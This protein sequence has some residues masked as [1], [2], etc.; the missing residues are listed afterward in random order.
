M[1]FQEAI[2]IQ[3]RFV[4][5]VLQVL[6]DLNEARAELIRRGS[7]AGQLKAGQ[8]RLLGEIDAL[9]KR[10]DE[11]RLRLVEQHAESL[12]AAVEEAK[13]RWSEVG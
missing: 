13:Q 4:F 1:K 8:S 12:R 7:E 5:A 6:S 3:S 9:A 10:H 2:N 11:E